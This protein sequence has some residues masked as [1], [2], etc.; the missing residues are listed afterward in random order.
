MTPLDLVIWFLVL[1]SLSYLDLG[2]CDLR[3]YLMTYQFFFQLFKRSSF[4]FGNFCQYPN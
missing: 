2:S 4:C 3:F 1:Y